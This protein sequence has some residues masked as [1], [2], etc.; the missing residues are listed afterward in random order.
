[1]AAWDLPDA[2][3]VA[4]CLFQTLWNLHSGQRPDAQIKDY[5]LFYFDP[6][7]L[8]EEAEQGVNQRLQAACADLPIEI[9]AKNQARVHT[10]YPGYFGHP[11]PA[12]RDS[13]DGMD[14]FL[15]RC[16]CVGLQNTGDFSAMELYAPY[17]LDALYEGL[18]SPNPLCDHPALFA[19]KAQ[20]YRAR[21]PWLRIEAG[22][23]SP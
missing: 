6:T 22:G 8:S 13:R 1:M 17:G 12:L 4:G 2:W 3:L 20:S 9:E 16:T 7:D 21:W 14:R 23:E 15:V 10:W 5:D 11:Y 18:L 19:A